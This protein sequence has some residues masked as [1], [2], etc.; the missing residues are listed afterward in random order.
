MLNHHFVRLIRA[1][2]RLTS[3]L[4]FLLLRN[5]ASSLRSAAHQVLRTCG[6]ILL[7]G[8]VA[9]RIVTHSLCTSTLAARTRMSSSSDVLKRARCSLPHI[10]G[11]LTSIK[12]SVFSQ[13]KVSTILFE[14]AQTFS[15]DAVASSTSLRDVRMLRYAPHARSHKRAV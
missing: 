5:R 6:L 10:E 2:H 13:E 7:S 9:P 8:A 15:D 14:K 11:F 3:L 12:L 1:A 4:S